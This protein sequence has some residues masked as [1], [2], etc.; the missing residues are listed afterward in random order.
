[1]LGPIKLLTGKHKQP[2]HWVL[3]EWKYPHHL[4]DH[5]QISL[6]FL[7]YWPGTSGNNICKDLHGGATSCSKMTWCCNLREQ[8]CRHGHGIADHVASGVIGEAWRE[9]VN[10]VRIISIMRLMLVQ[11]SKNL[12]DPVWGLTNWRVQAVCTSE[13]V[14]G[15][16]M[17]GYILKSLSYLAYAKWANVL[18]LCKQSSNWSTSRFMS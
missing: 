8:S 2:K 14:S 10:R 18:S 12:L 16:I 1:M 4:P 7:F 11:K 5:S 15:T 13:R 3:S 6:S 17:N 9:T